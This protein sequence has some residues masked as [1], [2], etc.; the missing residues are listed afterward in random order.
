MFTVCRNSH[1]LGRKLECKAIC[2]R[3]CQTHFNMPAAVHFWWIKPIFSH[4]YLWYLPYKSIC[5]KIRQL[6]GRLSV[7]FLILALAHRTLV[8]VSVGAGIILWAY[9][10]PAPHRWDAEALGHRW[11]SPNSPEKSALSPASGLHSP[12][13]HGGNLKP[14]CR[15]QN[16]TCVG[17]FKVR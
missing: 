2:K 8:Q 1:F 10:S 3:L 5:G 17:L 13:S 14:S 11:L 6:P 9:L 7:H 16:T 4:F 12:C 15:Y